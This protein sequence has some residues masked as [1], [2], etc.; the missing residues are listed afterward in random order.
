[1]GGGAEKSGDCQDFRRE[2]IRKR[3]NAGENRVANG[4]KS[5]SIPL[6]EQK[7]FTV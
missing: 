2:S 5:F 4:D 6:N 1:L 3:L 7:Y